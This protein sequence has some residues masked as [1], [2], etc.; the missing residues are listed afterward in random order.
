MKP[1]KPFGI[2]G[3]DAGMT[4]DGLDPYRNSR[5]FFIEHIGALAIMMMVDGLLLAWCF[6]HEPIGR[7]KNVVGVLS[8]K[9]FW[10]LDTLFM[11][12][13]RCLLILAR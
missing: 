2:A 12:G 7:L 10:H 11:A 13:G 9:K 5:D 3:G 8:K 1:C 6:C 4:G